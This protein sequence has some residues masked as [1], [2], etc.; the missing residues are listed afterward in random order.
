M[1][2]VALLSPVNPFEPLDGHRMAVESDVNAILDNGLGLGVLTFLYGHQKPTAVPPCD[3]RYFSVK[4]G[5]FAVR[6]LRGLFGQVPPSSERLYTKDSIAGVRRALKEWKPN[7]VVVDDVAMGGYISHIR[8]TAPGAKIILRT[9]N[10]MHDIRREQLEKTTGPAR[11]AVRFDTERYNDY[12]RRSLANADAHWAITPA[13]ADRMTEIYGVPSGFLSVSIPMGRYTK[14]GIEEGRNNH[15]IHVG[16]LDFRRRSDLQSFLQRS[17]PKV[18]AI[19]AEAAVTFAGTLH[20]KGIH[21]PGVKYA[22]PVKDD[23]AVYRQGRFALN[24]Q[25]TTGGIKIKTLTSLAAGR[26]LISTAHG[27]E[28]V[29]IRSGEHYWD[30]KTFL[31]SRLRDFLSDTDGLLKMANAGRGWVESHHSRKAIATQFATLL[32]TF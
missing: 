13:D 29:P 20:G 9:H 15:F 12:E 14:I 32:Q 10:V 2:D 11:V 26:T 23:A 17:W 5:S 16:T 21:A 19:D 4:A 31:S 30:M 3:T 28:G 18:R 22:G 8:D 7:Y 24:F 25:Q 1:L 6:L 27:I